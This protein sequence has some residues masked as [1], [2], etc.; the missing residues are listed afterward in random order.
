MSAASSSYSVALDGGTTN[1]RARLVRDGRII[2]TV[3]RSVGVRDTVLAAGSTSSP[4]AVA[5][6]EALQ[7]IGG[8]AGGVQPE[9]IVAAGMLSSEF[10]LTSVPHVIAPAGLDDLARG[11]LVRSLP[12]VSDLPIA[13]VPG[14]RTPPGA[15]PDGWMAADL[16]RGE[17]CETFGILTA[18]GGGAPGVYLWPGSHTKLIEVDAEGRIVRS[19]TTLAGELTEALARHTLIAGSLPGFSAGRPGHRPR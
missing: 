18:S 8:V 6:R 3:R 12:E 9:L 16:M 2:A 4:L 13:F 17:E 10:G 1:T 15:G 14:V 5:V 19:Q 11:V 7:E